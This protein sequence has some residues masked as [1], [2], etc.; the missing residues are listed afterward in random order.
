MWH[1]PENPFLLMPGG[2]GRRN[3]HVYCLVSHRNNHAD[4]VQGRQK[5]V[6]GS[7]HTLVRRKCLVYCD[8][9]VN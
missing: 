2:I 3:L 9:Y 7:F 5:L 4:R 8:F 6:R 1:S